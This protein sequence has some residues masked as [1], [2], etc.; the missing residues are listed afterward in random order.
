MLESQLIVQLSFAIITPKANK[1]MLFYGS[2]LLS[3]FSI[4]FY[5][6]FL[7]A[8]PSN[9]HPLVALA[10]TYAIATVICL[11]L[12]LVFPPIPSLY[13]SLRQINWISGALAPVIVGVELGFLLAYRAGWNISIGGLIANVSVAVLLIPVGNLIFTERLSLTQIIGIGVCILGLILINPR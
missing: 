2:M 4:L 10:A 11:I 12:L 9:A 7:K 8:V 3:I 13:E 1:K 5:H 6:L